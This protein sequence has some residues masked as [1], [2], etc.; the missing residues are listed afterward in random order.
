MPAWFRQL[1]DRLGDGIEA[2]VRWRHRRRLRR[3]GWADALEPW[4]ARDSGAQSAPH[5]GPMRAGNAVDVLIDGAEALPA[6][7]AAILG[8]R[9]SVHIAC[10]HASP[11]FKMTRGPQSRPLRDVLA[12]AASRVPVRLL[13]W[14]GP[15][16]PVYQPT[17][18]TVRSAVEGFER[19]SR[20]ECAVDSRGKL[21]HCHHEKIVVV[22]GEVAFVGG[23]D[24]TDLQGDRYDTSEHQP[25]PELR[26]HDVAARVRGP[27]VVDIERHFAG[28]WNEVT[29]QRVAEPTAPA[30]AG[31][32]GVQVVRTM[33]EKTYSFV[34][35]GDFSALKAYVAALHSAERFV[36]LENQF[37]WSPEIIDVL[38]ERLR[39][40]PEGFRLLLVLPIRPSDAKETT[41][42]QLGRLLTAD[43]GRG[44]LLATTIVGR[45]APGSPPVYVHAKVGIVDDR[46]L[47]LGS[48]N[49]NERSLFNDTEVNVVTHDGDFTRST[50]LRL[51]SEHTERPIDELDREPCEVVDDT[52]R[53]IAEE[54]ADRARRGLPLTHRLSLLDKVSRRID[55]LEGPMRGL[56][57]DG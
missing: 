43:D 20:V 18:R 8:A 5:G 44:R 25:R 3:L 41:R 36:Y 56:L 6:I 28:R 37:L 32:L 4:N 50:R 11:D 13:M 15:P 22:D 35:N 52:W 38:S 27:A 21:V 31:P 39:N 1:D 7:E 40:A 34:P 54:Q 24:F 19:D 26:W 47:T 9:R 14:G 45:A 23:L 29:G 55:R 51:W 33:P 42:G 57:V 48:V 17:R 16:L 10:W 49:L 46:W 2:V 12:E 53:P 30:P